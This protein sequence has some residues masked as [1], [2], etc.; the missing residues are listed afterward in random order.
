MLNISLSQIVL[1]LW[2]KTPKR[3]K[4]LK[5]K[6]DKTIFKY[7]LAFLWKTEIQRPNISHFKAFGMKNLQYEIRVPQK[8]YRRDTIHYCAWYDFLWN[9]HYS[10]IYGHLFLFQN[11][12]P[13]SKSKIIWWNHR[14]LPSCEYS[15]IY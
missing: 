3:Q 12:A 7:F 15:P 13:M 6:F 14:K 11:D 9:R 10:Q 4:L 2:H 1:K 5:H 8:I